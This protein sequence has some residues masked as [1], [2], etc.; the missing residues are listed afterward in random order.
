MFY[1]PRIRG[2]RTSAVALHLKA[3]G[4]CL[5]AKVNGRLFDGMSAP[6]VRSL[7]IAED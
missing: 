7:L 1:A 5:R 6:N 4:S 3:S 2:Q